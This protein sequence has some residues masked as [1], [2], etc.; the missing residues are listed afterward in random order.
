MTNHSKTYRSPLFYVGDKYKL[1]PKIRK[2]FP[3][4]INRFIEPFTGGGSVFLNV[5]ANEYLLN[6]IDTN[7]INIHHFL[8]EQSENPKAFFDS[9]FE[10]V[11]EYNLSHSYIKDIV[12]QE[13]KDEWIKTYY[14]KFN[15]HG[16]DKLKAD[17]NSSN[18]KS[19][20]HLYL[21]LIYGFNRML[22][23]NS[24]GEYNLPVGN[25]DFNKNTETALH[26]Y[27]RL[28]KQKNIQFFNLDFL[29]FFRQIEFQEDDFVYLDPPYLITFSEYNKLWNEE[30]EKRLL[31]FLEWLD[32]QNVKFAVSNVSHYKGKINQ[33]FLEWSKQHNSF[34][35]KSNY[36]SYHDNSNKE[37]KE[38]LI[39]N[40]EP[41]II[42]PTQETINFSELETVLR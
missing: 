39:T 18:E 40:Y 41:E 5:N 8:I 35:I 13:L 38:V 12:P 22:R 15:K 3:K 4:M 32:T 42:V 34:D 37:F 31:D 33:Q 30:T 28:T 7:V 2:Y 27:F 24:K 25:V 6:D 36:I 16:F 10:V 1:Y 19:V 20:L 29:D 17:Y 9:V 23:F 26:D 21:L 11:Q 14:A